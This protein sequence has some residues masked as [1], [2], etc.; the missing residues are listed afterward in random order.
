MRFPVSLSGPGFPGDPVLQVRLQIVYRCLKS[1]GVFCPKNVTVFL[2][3]FKA[4][5]TGAC[6]KNP[7]LL[8][9]V[10]PKHPDTSCFSLLFSPEILW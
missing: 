9:L 3:A 4:Y 1:A 6:G 7:P 5:Q 8:H 10:T 2:S